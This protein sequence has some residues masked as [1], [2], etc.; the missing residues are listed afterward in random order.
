MGSIIIAVGKSDQGNLKFA[1]PLLSE[2]LRTDSLKATKLKLEKEVI[3]VPCKST[4]KPAAKPKPKK[5]K[6]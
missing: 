5:S 6:K 2:I 3:Q 4:K 1:Y